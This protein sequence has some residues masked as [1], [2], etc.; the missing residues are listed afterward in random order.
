MKKMLFLSL[1]LLTAPALAFDVNGIRLGGREIEVV[2][3]M[4]S[5]NC[6]ALE[7]KSDAADRR[8]DDAR[9]SVGGVETRIT[10]FLKAG[11]VQAYDIRFDVKELERLKTHLK[12]RWAARLPDLVDLPRE[13]AARDL[14][15]QQL[16]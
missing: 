10:V 5:A 13:I 12:S 7:W 4:P 8:C 3:A 15:A 16:V 1:L 11:A 2:R 6:K 9:V 14:Q